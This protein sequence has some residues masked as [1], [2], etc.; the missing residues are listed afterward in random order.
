MALK[1]WA[2]WNAASV[3]ITPTEIFPARRVR[4]MFRRE[5]AGTGVHIEVASFNP[6]GLYT[7]ADWWK[8]EDGLISFQNEVLKYLYYRW[9]Y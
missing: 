7:R 6:P 5:F 8:A 2:D 1:G 4:W 3:L 9:N